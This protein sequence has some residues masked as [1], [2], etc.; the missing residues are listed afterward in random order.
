MPPLQAPVCCHVKLTPFT[1]STVGEPSGGVQWVPTPVH[2]GFTDRK[3]GSIGRLAAAFAM[4]PGG[5]LER[6]PLQRHAVDPD[7]A[8]LLTRSDGCGPVGARPPA[9][10]ADT[11][12]SVGVD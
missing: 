11:D 7:D 5:A 3:P 4:V 10:R 12:H 6:L 1:G 8:D 9:R 2:T